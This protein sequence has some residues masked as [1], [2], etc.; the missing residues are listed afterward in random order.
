MPRTAGFHETPLEDITFVDFQK[1]ICE[2]RFETNTSFEHHIIQRRVPDRNGQNI[3][4]ALRAIAV[5]LR[6]GTILGMHRC[7]HCDGPTRLESRTWT[8]CVYRWTCQ[9]SG[10]K[11]M[12]H[13]VNVYGFLT[14]VHISNWMPVLHMI[15]LLRIG[16]FRGFRS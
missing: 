14:A 16:F 15:N 7:T 9:S 4:L 2:E 12:C 6:T 3:C 5:F 8:R 10:H 13:P 1:Q 11:H